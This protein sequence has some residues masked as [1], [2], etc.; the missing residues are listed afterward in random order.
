[1]APPGTLAGVT[2]SGYF[3]FDDRIIPIGGGTLF[4]ANLLTDLAFTWNLITYDESTANT[5]MLTFDATGALVPTSFFGN[6]CPA[7]VCGVLHG[8]N[9]W[10][11]VISD[12]G[13]LFEYGVPL[14]FGIQF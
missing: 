14:V 5:G 12:S 8:T 9:D 1:M 10:A 2:S 11:F 7:G 4:Q 6:K 13:V 3:S